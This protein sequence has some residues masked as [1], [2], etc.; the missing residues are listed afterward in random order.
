MY[1]TFSPDSRSP[2]PKSQSQLTICPLGENEPEPLKSTSRGG[3]P[4]TGLAV[5]MEIGLPVADT[6]RCV[7]ALAPDVLVT[8][9]VTVNTDDSL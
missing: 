2:F 1:C 7:T 5:I 9:R 4:A 3:L 8:P 6:K